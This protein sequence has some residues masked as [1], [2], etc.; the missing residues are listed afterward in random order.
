MVEFGGGGVC[1]FFL[2]SEGGGLCNFLPQIGGG[3]CKFFTTYLSHL[4]MSRGRPF[5]FFLFLQGPR[6]FFSLDIFR[7]HPQIIN[8]RPLRPLRIMEKYRS[9]CKKPW[10]K[11]REPTLE[12]GTEAEKQKRRKGGVAASEALHSAEV[13]DRCPLYVHH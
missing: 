9:A 6:N 4:R 11:R 2:L 5:D 12:L 10:Q 1:N 7:S 3:S 8:G 13:T